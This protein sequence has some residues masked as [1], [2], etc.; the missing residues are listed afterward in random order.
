M[1][2]RMRESEYDQT[3][4]KKVKIVIPPAELIKEFDKQK[5]PLYQ[6]IR[7]LMMQ[8]DKLIK[9]RDALLPRLMSGK[10]EV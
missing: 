5:E 10:L 1:T 2:M 8:N 4:V 3:K 7:A 6:T 9:Q